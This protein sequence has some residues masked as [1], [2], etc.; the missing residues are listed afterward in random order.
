M[1]LSPKETAIIVSVILV[2]SGQSRARLSSK[3]IK[4]ISGRKRQLR[5]AFIV[6]VTEALAEY[7]WSMSELDI[8]GY[9]VIATRSL[10]AAKPVTAKRYL[11]D[12]E[13]RSLKRGATDFSGLERE[14]SPERD[15]EQG[16]E[17]E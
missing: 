12:D 8:G 10:E 4:F 11:R 6:T 7:S 9:G 2:R 3:T 14:I 13:L 5:S 15:D 16:D 17:T 1:Y